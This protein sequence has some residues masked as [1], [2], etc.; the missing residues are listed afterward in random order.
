MPKIIRT[1]PN[2]I[3][4]INGIEFE[5]LPDEA[6]SISTQDVPD[7]LAQQFLAV[8]G[9]RLDETPAPAPA[10]AQAPT[11]PVAPRGKKAPA[12]VPAPPSAPAPAPAPVETTT[13]TPETGDAETSDESAF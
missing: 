12:P 11:A 2:F 13:A 8:P 4:L 6:G 10:P 5:P 1:L 3:P 7:E 9:F